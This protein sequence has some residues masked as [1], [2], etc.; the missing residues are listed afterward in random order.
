MP[1]KIFIFDYIKKLMG[2]CPMRDSLRNGN[3]EHFFSEFKSGNW[4]IQLIP[5]PTSLQDSRI[6]KA[7][8]SI[9]GGWWGV[10][11]IAL[12]GVSSMVLRT[13]SPE[14]SFLILFSGLI[15]FL[16]PLILFLNRPGTVK[17]NSGKIIIMRSLRKP[18]VIE[19]EDLRQISVTKNEN[20]PFAGYTA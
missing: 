14:G 13:Y 16:T 5:S 8:A 2:W 20:Y 17:V 4:N 12:A 1:D 19:Q 10:I 6:L 11:I 9:F 15:I 18:L 7:R 3:Q